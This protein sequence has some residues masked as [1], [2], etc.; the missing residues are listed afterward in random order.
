MRGGVVLLTACQV[1][2]ARAMMRAT[3]ADL[4]RRTG[5]GERT[6]RRIEGQFGTPNVTLDVLANLQTFFESEGMT[7]IPDDGGPRGPGVCWATYPGR[8]VSGR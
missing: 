4:A 3:I 6:I 5:V 8:K 2:A 7:F 1:R